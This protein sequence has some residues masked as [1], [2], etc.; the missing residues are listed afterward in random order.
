MISIH[1]EEEQDCQQLFKKI[2]SY[3]EK[4][5]HLG[6]KGEVICND[7][8][9]ITI[10]YTDEYVFYNSFQPLLVSILTNHVIATKESEWLTEIIENMFYFTDPE[11]QEQILIIARSIL[12]G[13]REDLPNITPFFKRDT[14]IYDAFSSSLD[15][16]TTFYYEPFLTFRLKDY[17]EMLIDCVEIA[18]DEY[19]LEQEYQN[20]IE[21]LRQ[22]LRITPSIHDTLHLV[23]DGEQFTFYDKVYKQIHVN[24]LAKHLREELVFEED[25]EV[26][27][28]V[29]SP[30]V[31]MLPSHLNVY[32][33]DVDHGILLTIQALFEERVVLQPLEAFR[34]KSQLL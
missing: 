21:N 25:L 3:L 29:I 15:H 32:S 2:M 12:E 27:E 9:V 30:L 14:F 1:F 5:K 6:L 18:I 28:M 10:N 34:I 8:D 31:S 17:G 11:E 19:F 16:N 26:S 24:E 33:D 20:M 13:D 7:I 4:Y 22:F 23:Y